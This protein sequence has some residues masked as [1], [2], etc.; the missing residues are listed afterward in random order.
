MGLWSQTRPSLRLRGLIPRQPPIQQRS[1]FSIASDKSALTAVGRAK[2]LCLNMIVRNEAV[3]IGRC[4]AS[5]VD[6]I[7]CWVISDTGSSDGTPEIIQEFF[8]KRRIP[9]KL[10]Q[11][12]FEN[13]ESSRN[14]ALE[15]A[16]SSSFDFDYI[17]FC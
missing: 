5:I 9:G 1:S 4:L 14:A 8:R 15:C 2:D 6:H 12:P 3:N 13:F 16:R 11:K 17:L 7:S 10:H